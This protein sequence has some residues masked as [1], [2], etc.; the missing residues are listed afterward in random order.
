[1][2]V[3]NEIV[4]ENQK[5]GNPESEW[6]LNDWTLWNNG[7]I[8]GFSTDIS[9]SAGER[10]DFK[11]NSQVANYHIDIYRVGYYGGDGARKV[12]TI[13]QHADQATNQPEALFDP[14]TRMADAGNWHVT[15]SWDVPDDAVS[16][17]YIAKLV[18]D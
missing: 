6:G 10:V 2:A 5:P 17:V 7:V 3:S 12:A 8:E 14:N 18:S 15:D 16:G 11:I 13:E 4:L 1:M 9:A